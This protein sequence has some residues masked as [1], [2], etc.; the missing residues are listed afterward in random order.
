MVGGRLFK[1][2]EANEVVEKLNMEN[3][4]STALGREAKIE[5]ASKLIRSNK[6]IEFK[7]FIS[8]LNDINECNEQGNTLAM[9]ASWNGNVNCLKFT[10]ENGGDLDTP[11]V[12]IFGSRHLP[13]LKYL[14]SINKLNVNGKGENGFTPLQQV[15]N[16]SSGLFGEYDMSLVADRIECMNFLIDEGA[17]LNAINNFGRSAFHALAYQPSLDFLNALLIHSPDPALICEKGKTP[18]MYAYDTDI[19][20]R[21]RAFFPYL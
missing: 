10:F 14:K 9:V 3:C 8:N 5:T 11:G 16:I 17:E 21:I 2:I 19:E 13:I 1:Q 7:K 20:S 12:T 15:T 18:I 6:D 4:K